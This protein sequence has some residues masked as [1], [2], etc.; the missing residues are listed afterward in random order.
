MA[1]PLHWNRYQWARQAKK[2][3]FDETSNRR[4][5]VGSV[6]VESRGETGRK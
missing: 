6:A 2:T 5:T 4:F 1:N 3:F